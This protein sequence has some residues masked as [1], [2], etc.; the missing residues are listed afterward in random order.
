MFYA[1]E[2][3]KRHNI[4]YILGRGINMKAILYIFILFSLILTPVFLSAEV[5]QGPGNN[6]PL[7][8]API[9]TDDQNQ[10][11]IKAEDAKK[12]EGKRISWVEKQMSLMALSDKKNI[13]YEK[14]IANVYKRMKD[15]VEWN[16]NYTLQRFVEMAKKREEIGNTVASYGE[17][18]VLHK[19]GSYIRYFDGRP[20]DVFNLSEKDNYGNTHKVNLMNLQ[21]EDTDQFVVENAGTT[22]THLLEYI[23]LEYDPAGAINY[24]QFSG[25]QYNSNI[26][27]RP[28]AYNLTEGAVEQTPALAL[29]NPNTTEQ[30]KAL[31][32]K[33]VTSIIP[34]IE[35]AMAY[36]VTTAFS[37]I[38]YYSLAEDNATKTS[39]GGVYGEKKSYDY[40]LTS[41]DAP[42]VTETGTVNN[43]QYYLLDK[44]YTE[45]LSTYW[46]H[47]QNATLINLHHNQEAKE[48]ISHT[49]STK[50]GITKEMNF[51]DAVYDN[52]NSLSSYKQNILIN[53]T[54]VGRYYYS[55]INYDSYGR[56]SSYVI[57]GNT[58]GL[59]F[60]SVYSDITYDTLSR[61]TSY[62]LR[63]NIDG[64][65]TN[66]RFWNMIYNNLWQVTDYFYS[67]DNISHHR[68]DIT[69]NSIGLVASYTDISTQDGATTTTLRQ[70]T[71]NQNGLLSE[72]VEQ[73]LI[74]G[75]NVH[76][77]DYIWSGNITYNS[78]YAV[79]SF[80]KVTIRDTNATTITNYYDKIPSI[81]NSLIFNGATYSLTPIDVI[82]MGFNSTT[83]IFTEK[84]RDMN[85]YRVGEKIGEN[86]YNFSLDSFRGK[87]KSYKAVTR[88]TTTSSDTAEETTL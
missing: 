86:Y 72:Y 12:A 38:D 51:Y 71:Y 13:F 18:L 82:S 65:T 46:W 70:N 57:E 61:T 29:T 74:Q 80:D 81:I 43:V 1:A 7:G 45:P 60:T 78:I 30:A 8:I 88:T 17:F 11:F 59:G 66:Y 35:S 48:A 21:Y 22:N 84:W 26:S 24:V 40:T 83:T 41:T 23:K 19:D 76:E 62:T 54:E 69:Y 52:Y 75:D 44:L 42:D 15:Q 64:T 47:A 73:K 49:V 55:N 5:G 10:G 2:L 4:C 9:K 77:F 33:L 67:I 28:S 36:K 32:E 85:Y 20:T 34:T 39:A 14:G 16:K 53:S 68:F 87:L 79:S 56:Q 27:D 6:S 3:E 63:E 50:L 58:Y 37:N 31:Y 25:G